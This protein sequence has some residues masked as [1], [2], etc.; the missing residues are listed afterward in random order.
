MRFKAPIVTM[1]AAAAALASIGTGGT[2]GDVDPV[3]DIPEGAIPL[4]TYGSSI[5]SESGKA[6]GGTAA[7]AGDVVCTIYAADPWH[8]PPYVTGYGWQYCSGP[9]TTHGFRIT[10]QK[11]QWATIWNDLDED[12]IVSSSEDWLQETVTAECIP[13]QRTYRIIVDGFFTM[14]GG[15]GQASVQS[16]DIVITCNG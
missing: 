3:P 13:V 15:G 11:H 6:E 16:Y 1:L 2:S 12:Y 8:A 4:L 5:S 10:L 9:Y 14:I 7:A